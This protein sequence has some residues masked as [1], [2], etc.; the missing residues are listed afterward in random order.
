VL[1]THSRG[2]LVP[3]NHEGVADAPIAAGS[4]FLRSIHAAP[5]DADGPLH[6][7]AIASSAAGQD[8]AVG[9][10]LAGEEQWNHPLPRGVQKHPVEFVAWG[11]VVGNGQGQWLLAG[12]DGSLHILSAAGEVLDQ[13]NY[14]AALSGLAVTPIN[15]KPA[16]LISTA[17]GIAAWSVQ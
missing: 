7:L 14:G 6:Y 13:F 11:D 12:P 17:S 2:T 3:I 1:C 4:Y 9:L 8:T 5:L 10:N 15:G 16:L